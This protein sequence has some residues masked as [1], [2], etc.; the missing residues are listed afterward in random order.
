MQHFQIIFI[1]LA[2]TPINRIQ[3]KEGASRKR[4]ETI[5][6]TGSEAVCAA[7]DPDGLL[8]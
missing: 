7:D 4:I 3:A 2:V 8:L 5:S 1:S 6:N